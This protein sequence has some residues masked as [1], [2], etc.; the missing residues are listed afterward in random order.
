MI[1]TDFVDPAKD[2]TNGT[3][4]PPTSAV[5]C[6]EHHPPSQ[7]RKLQ[8]EACRDLST[9]TS[10]WLGSRCRECLHQTEHTSPFN[11]CVLISLGVPVA[12][13][14]EKDPELQTA[15]SSRQYDAKKAI[16]EYAEIRINI[17]FYS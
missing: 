15:D 13:L 2:E 6:Q 10:L 7:V 16:L 1:E 11:K 4:L 3:A 5:T 8:D 9:P 17:F 14:T 12:S